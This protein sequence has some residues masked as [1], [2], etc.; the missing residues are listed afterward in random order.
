MGPIYHVTV[1][2][3]GS[4][5]VSAGLYVCVTQ[6]PEFIKDLMGVSRAANVGGN[7]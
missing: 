4:G 2:Y 6:R 5:R 3:F 7:S 1:C